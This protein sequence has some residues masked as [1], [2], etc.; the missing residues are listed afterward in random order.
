MYVT[1]ATTA[2]VYSPQKASFL[3]HSVVKDKNKVNS[4]TLVEF[5]SQ[6]TAIYLFLTFPI[7]KFKYS[8]KFLFVLIPNSISH[9]NRLPVP[10]VNVLFVNL[11]VIYTVIYFL[12]DSFYSVVILLGTRLISLCYF[13]YPCLGKD[14]IERKAMT[15]TSMDT[16]G[17]SCS[18][19]S[20]SSLTGGISLSKQVTLHTEFMNQL[21]IWHSLLEK[22]GI[23]KETYD[24][25]HTILK[26]NF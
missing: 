6:K 12:L 17:P 1:W 25:Q 24:L 4:K 10:V 14:F 5:T 21:A 18:S 15:P 23:T 16:A 20:P 13:L 7:I 11:N 22:G 3:H 8:D 9:W 26:E 19:R 2:F